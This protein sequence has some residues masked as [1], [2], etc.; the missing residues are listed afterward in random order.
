MHAYG[1]DILRTIR[2]GK[3]RFFSIM[4]V[5]TLGVAMFSGLQAACND[6]RRSA[7]VFFDEYR[8]HDL[9]IVSTHGLT[10]EDIETLRALP[11]T[12][13]V[14]GRFAQTVSAYFSEN[15]M[16]IEL[17]VLY[18]DTLDRPYLLEGRMAE[19]PSEVIVS[20][21]F[22]RD[23][24]LGIGDTFTI[25]E[26]TDEED[27]EETDPY[28]LVTGYTITGVYTDVRNVNNPLG[29]TAFRGGLNVT[30]HAYVRP[31]AVSTDVY[32][33]VVVTVAG[34][35]ESFSFGPDYERQ[36]RVF[37][38]YLES[39]I[40]AQ[41]EKA[42]YDALVREATEKVDEAEEEARQELEDALNELTEG[43]QTLEEELAEARQELDDA[44]RKIA[45]AAA[46]L[47]QAQ[48]DIAAA[49][50][51]LAEK[52]AEALA[53]IQDAREE[54]GAGWSELSMAEQQL[55]AKEMELAAGEAQL[56]EAKQTLEASEAQ[57]AA[58]RQQAEQ[59]V[60]EATAAIA[61]LQT[62]KTDLETQLA[63]ALQLQTDLQ[64][65][66]TA[67]TI[68]QEE[69]EQLSQLPAKIT[70]LQEG[71]AQIEQELTRAQTGL[72]TAQQGLD[73]VN[74][75]DAATAAARSAARAQ[76]AA[77]ETQLAQGRAQINAGRAEIEANRAR[78]EEAEK[79]LDEEEQ[80][81]LAEIASAR[82][83]IE[84]AK[85][86]VLTGA[87]DLANAR[88]EYNEGLTSYEEG[89]EEGE[90][91]LREGYEEYEE[92]KREAEEEIR[93]ARQK[94][95]DMDM[96]TWYIR[97]RMALSACSNLD[98]DS[99][100]I[101]SIGTVFPVVFFLVAI[102]IS[103]TAVTRMVE[104]DRGLIGTYKALGFSD[105]RIRRKYLVFT[106]AA[107]L[108]GAALG[109]VGAFIGLP[110]FLFRIFDIM[111]VLPFY[112]TRFLLPHGLLGPALFTLGV[113]GAAY[114]SCTN[115]MR[116]MPASLMRPKSPKS[117]SR[118]LLERVTM[119]WRRMSFLNK[120]TARNLFRYKKR[121]LMTVFG[122]TGCMALLLFGFAIR[123]SVQDL[124]PRQYEQTTK[125][126]LLVVGT[127]GNEEEG[128]TLHDYL[129]HDEEIASYKEA[130][131]FNVR[132]QD[133]NGTEQTVQLTVLE[134][135]EDLAQYIRLAD[136][137]GRELALSDGD[138]YMSRNA[139]RMM[140]LSE[141]DAFTMQLPD[142][143]TATLTLTKVTQNYLGNVMYMTRATYESFFSPEET[144]GAMIILRDDLENELAYHE[145]FAAREGIL[146]CLSTT[147]IKD[148]FAQTFL[149]MDAV[150]VLIIVMSAALAFAVLFTLAT[151][152]I[153]ERERELATIKVLGF[154]DREVHLY[155]DKET[156][157]LT[158]IGIA[159]GAPVGRLFAET[160]PV[161]LKIPAMYLAVSLHPVS[162]AYAAGLTIVFALAVNLITDRILDRIN[163]VE[164]LK[165]VE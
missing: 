133:V 153:S 21:R 156:L 86:E 80:T 6:L 107:A 60:A 93:E 33:A 39:H 40:K 23:T 44:E 11:E 72:T 10:E 143:E 32:T 150:V 62:Q 79:T 105:I 95:A 120:V 17:E 63:A 147:Q 85:Q 28:F 26:Q 75:E 52:E 126:D 18:E 106:S 45:D 41:R 37:R 138:V 13:A 15:V 128:L 162:Y 127:G 5:T 157:I 135:G 64:G 111:Y 2:S 87:T 84:S 78:L 144:N 152:N 92:G 155:V 57:L 50:Q 7:D 9:E 98:S 161:I 110:L 160:L 30:P 165:S 20:Q 55:A 117:G 118:V 131:I 146:T 31:Q 159:L 154:F 70:A 74:A 25:E 42:R 102:L 123:D 69:Y 24:G 43:E 54:L 71:I 103:L 22:V 137:A 99:D 113:V 19:L 88:A 94:I 116:E 67:G 4:I 119:L 129:T 35:R 53:A 59:G 124:M 149:L 97:D 139:T 114:L 163:M 3:K 34:A 158:L 96:T 77:S 109:T 130:L 134:Q 58:A 46:E 38:Q 48:A 101:E 132:V 108:L 27:D 65:K 104:E 12:E 140:N 29:A 82:E 141:G 112:L 142:L 73:T 115:A 61:A 66:E 122:I 68:T 76:I 51:E 36:V 151:T 164:A 8:L 16:D 14:E 81:A 1:K 91:E 136:T 125:Y 100:A 47:T 148:Q 56:A 89:K 49:E 83:E 145:E 90:Q 121:M